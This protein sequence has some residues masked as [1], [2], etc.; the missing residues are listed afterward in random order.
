MALK[1]TVI[2]RGMNPS[3]ETAVREFRYDLSGQWWKGNTHIHSTASDGGKTFL[4]LQEMY[5]AAGYHFLFRTDHWV[6]SDVQAGTAGASPAGSPAGSPWLWLDGI[7]LDGRDAVGAEYHVVALGSFHGLQREIGL[8]A[9]MESARAQG[10]ILILAHPQWTGNTFDDALRWN[11]DG[12]EVYNHVCRWLNGK[13]D[14]GAYWNAVLAQA[15]AVLGLAVDDA[16]IRPEHPGWNGGWIQVNARA[17]TPADI[18]AAL[19]A[20]NFYASTGPVLESLAFDGESVSV[21]CSPAQFIRLVGPGSRGARVG[22]FDGSL[23]AEAVF[24]VPAAWKY[25][26]L[27]VED[28]AGRRAWTNNLFR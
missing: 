22:A 26:Y 28:A 2:I 12:V 23:F 4:E 11:F 25:A 8:Q 27:E 10:G 3:Q 1:F 18:L 5:S 16:H 13:G 17:C 15:P 9:A 19:R 24:T 6:A 20:G 21:R 7:E 14:G